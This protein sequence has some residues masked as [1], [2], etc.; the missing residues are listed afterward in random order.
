MRRARGG[1][2][3]IVATLIPVLLWLWQDPA[4]QAWSLRNFGLAAGLTGIAAWALNVIL[5]SRAGLLQR[6]FGGI[7][8][9]YAAHRVNGRVVYLLVAAHL[10]LIVADRARVSVPSA[11]RTFSPEA[12]ASVLLGV[13]A[14]VLLTIGLGLTLYA[15]LSHEIF[16]YVQRGLGATFIVG[17]LHAFRMPSAKGVSSGATFYLATL[18][19]AAV[20]AFVYRSLLGNVLVRRSRYVVSD[21]HELDPTVMEI[22]MSP[23][24]DRRLR[25][26]PGQFVFATFYSEEFESQFHPVSVSAKGLAGSIILRPGDLRDQFHPFSLTSSPDDRDLKLAVKAVGS[27]TKAL[28]RLRP[29]AIAVIEGPYGNFS[30]LQV[31]SPR[32]IWIA[33]G[34]GITPF[35]SMARSLP[36]GAFEVD[37]FYAVKARR[38]AYFF[39]ELRSMAAGRASFKVHLVTEEEDGFVSA[40]IVSG[41][42]ALEGKDILMCG[43]P[44]MIESLRGQF[45]AAGVPPGKVHSERFGFGPRR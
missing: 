30:Y 12:G 9:L 39:E 43:P 20:A 21:A 7:E 19:V 8:S 32:Q 23:V 13:G 37:L 25:Y 36:E 15:R 44:A 31:G 41:M 1:L 2:L 4:P 16:V 29:G 38:E 33:G 26:I 24:G 3:L 17:A 45:S 14:F 11:L 34:I 27:F 42:S 28:H 5:S 6:L 18:A 35:L 40:E 22:T 10:T